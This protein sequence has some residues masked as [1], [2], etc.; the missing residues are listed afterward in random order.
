MYSSVLKFDWCLSFILFLENC[1]STFHQ[2]H[3]P[4]YSNNHNF[5]LAYWFLEIFIAATSLFSVLW[6]CSVKVYHPSFVSETIGHQ[7]ICF[8]LPGYLPLWFFECLPGSLSLTSVFSIHL[9]A[10]LKTD[11]CQY[12]GT[13]PLLCDHS[14]LQITFKLLV[15]TLNS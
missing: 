10:I 13:P 15:L 3:L 5:W 4:A 7:E 6:L 1:N 2:D 12:S 8:S 11:L 14:V 9:E